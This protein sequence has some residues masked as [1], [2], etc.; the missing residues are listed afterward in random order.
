MGRIRPIDDHDLA[1]QWL[2]ALLNPDLPIHI[3]FAKREVIGRD[4]VDGRRAY[5][6]S[7]LERLDAIRIGTIAPAEEVLQRQRYAELLVDRV[8]Y[9]AIASGRRSGG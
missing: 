7:R 4:A 2:I 8:Q 3:S 6:I 9:L 1:R 5:L